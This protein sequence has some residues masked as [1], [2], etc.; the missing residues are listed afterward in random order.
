PQE[1]VSDIRKKFQYEE[2]L[3]PYERDL[4]TYLTY[5][6]AKQL[7]Y[8]EN[9]PLPDKDSI[10]RAGMRPKKIEFTH[11]KNP[12]DVGISLLAMVQRRSE[13]IKNVNKAET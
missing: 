4:V 7:G 9:T 6:P 8:F 2:I 5:G 1:V 10:M 11:N 13:L 12:L 3:S